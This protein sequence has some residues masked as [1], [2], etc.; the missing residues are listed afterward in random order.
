[1]GLAGIEPAT[2]ALSGRPGESH[3]IPICPASSRIRCSST[4]LKLRGRRSGT[5]RDALGP[6]CW[7]EVGMRILF[8]REQRIEI[9]SSADPD[10]SIPTPI[11]KGIPIW[12]RSGCDVRSGDVHP[13]TSGCPAGS[14][15]S[16]GSPMW[17]SSF[18]GDA[19]RAQR[20][21]GAVRRCPRPGPD[22]T[23]I[24]NLGT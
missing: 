1:V 7:D 18:E 24:P 4:S 8:S 9:G 17:R 23:G 12:P 11:P 20:G 15:V 3:C 14:L 19:G 5:L 21:P 10:K 2:S 22:P 6:N 16:R 13:A